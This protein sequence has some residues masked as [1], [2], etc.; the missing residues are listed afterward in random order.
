MRGLAIAGLA[1]A[2]VWGA[3]PMPPNTGISDADLQMIVGWVLA[4]K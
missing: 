3:V 4:V 1:S 2:G